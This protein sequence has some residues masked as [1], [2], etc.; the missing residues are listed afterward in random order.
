MVIPGSSPASWR[1]LKTALSFVALPRPQRRLTKLGPDDP[2]DR[3]TSPL[4]ARLTSVCAV[5]AGIP[6]RTVVP[7]P[8]QRESAAFAVVAVVTG[9]RPL[10]DSGDGARCI[11]RCGRLTNA[12]SVGSGVCAHTGTQSHG[13]SAIGPK[14]GG[15]GQPLDH[16]RQSGCCSIE[17]GPKR[18]I[19]PSPKRAGC[20]AKNPGKRHQHRQ[21]GRPGFGKPARSRTGGAGCRRRHRYR[22]GTATGRCAGAARPAGHPDSGRPRNAG[23]GGRARGAATVQQRAGRAGQAGPAADS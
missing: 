8:R 17:T 19:G 6:W 14:A 22:A 4:R 7:R 16:A 21:R 9:S 20:R 11:K 2:T 12:R 10:A 23:R 1:R 3:H 5:R 18:R 15:S 13:G